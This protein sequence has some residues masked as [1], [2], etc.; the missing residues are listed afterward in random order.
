MADTIGRAA[1]EIRAAAGDDQVLQDLAKSQ[2]ALAKA[3]ARRGYDPEDE[4]FEDEV[5]AQQEDDHD[6]FDQEEVEDQDPDNPDLGTGVDDLRGVAGARKRRGVK[7]SGRRRHEEAEEHLMRA[8]RRLR[9]AEKDEEEA[10]RDRDGERLDEARKSRE[11]AEHE[12]ERARGNM[13]KLHEELERARKNNVTED[14][15]AWAGDEQEYENDGRRRRKTA[16]EWYSD[17]EDAYYTNEDAD[18]EEDGE[19]PPDGPDVA[20]GNDTDQYTIG[21]HKVRS[22]RA[23]RRS[24]RGIPGKRDLY[25]SVAD[26]GRISEDL[27]DAAPALEE[28]L[29]I[30]GDQ[31]DTL[32]K[33]ASIVA[34]QDAVLG[35]LAKTVVQQGKV[36]VALHKSVTAMASQPVT[37]PA[38]GVPPQFGV[39]FGGR[40]KDGKPG[41]R[42]QKSRQDL[43]VEAEEGMRQG[44]IDSRTYNAIGRAQSAEEIVQIVPPQ[45][46]KALGW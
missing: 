1:E 28:L 8:R 39:L 12:L 15:P 35:A 24:Q 26:R 7:K 30:I 22:N 44:L 41:D 36:L 32:R 42:L 3:A 37:G 10:E 34:R 11:K 33:S 40:G 46:R 5:G 38:F 9:K 14:R 20:D 31:Q 25:K 4:E 43:M 6:E 17:S 45:T 19:V 23:M 2:R 16:Q 29:E 21:S 27:L 13:R 18:H